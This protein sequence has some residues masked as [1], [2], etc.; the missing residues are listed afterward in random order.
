MSSTR[1]MTKDLRN[2]EYSPPAASYLGLTV[3]CRRFR[4]S[5]CR[6]SKTP[7]TS[8]P[9]YRTCP[10]RV[11]QA[12]LD[13]DEPRFVRGEGGYDGRGSDHEGRLLGHTA[14]RARPGELNVV[15][16]PSSCATVPPTSLFVDRP[17]LCL[18]Q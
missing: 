16:W 6:P 10:P 18:L 8:L 3:N 13:D 17:G 14:G 9:R 5:A 12:M 1:P 11:L 15:A 4:T 2:G 7:S